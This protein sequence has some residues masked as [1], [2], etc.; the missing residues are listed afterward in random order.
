MIEIID[1]NDKGYS[2]MLKYIAMS[3]KTLAEK[4][5][6][7]LI[8]NADKWKIEGEEEA[9]IGAICDRLRSYS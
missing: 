1:P 2:A 6:R 9:L 4:L 8:Q 3:N 7:F 5:E